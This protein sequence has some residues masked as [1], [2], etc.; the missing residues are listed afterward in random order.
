MSYQQDVSPDQRS[1]FAVRFPK[2]GKQPLKETQTSEMNL[3]SS[4]LSFDDRLVKLAVLGANH[5]MAEPVL[6]IKGVKGEKV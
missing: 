1:E 4:D 3:S 2:E 6:G 5:T